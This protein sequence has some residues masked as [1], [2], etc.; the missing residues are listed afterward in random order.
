MTA[1][2]K[3]IAGTVI[4]DKTQWKTWITRQVKKQRVDKVRTRGWDTV[5]I[6]KTDI[7]LRYLEQITDESQ[8]AAL[9][10]LMQYILDRMAD[11]KKD[12]AVLAREAVEKLKRDGI[13]SVVPKNYNAGPAAE[14]RAQEILACLSRYRLF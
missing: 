5:S 2:A 3:F 1:K 6:D 10:Y 9:A 11:G 7:D 4:D 8:T 14:V 13:L 12:A